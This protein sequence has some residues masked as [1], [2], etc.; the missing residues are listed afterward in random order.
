M[1]YK[2]FP[3][4]KLSLKLFAKLYQSEGGKNAMGFA[5]VKDLCVFQTLGIC[6]TNSK[7]DP[8]LKSWKN[9]GKDG[10]RC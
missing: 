8:S 9:F 10:D 2:L 1:N 3:N 6:Q 7:I 5:V 4:L